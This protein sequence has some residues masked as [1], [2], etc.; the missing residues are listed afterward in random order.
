M[1]Q[2]QIVRENQADLINIEG[3]FPIFNKFPNLLYSYAP[4]HTYVSNL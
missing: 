3:Q 4:A 1:E 2:Q